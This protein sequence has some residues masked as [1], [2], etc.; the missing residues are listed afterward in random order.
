MRNVTLRACHVIGRIYVLHHRVSRHF[1]FV[2]HSA[3]FFSHT[4]TAASAHF[5]RRTDTQ[6]HTSTR[7]AINRKLCDLLTSDRVNR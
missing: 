2:V 4:R 1:R 3:L 5:I 7:L 6:T